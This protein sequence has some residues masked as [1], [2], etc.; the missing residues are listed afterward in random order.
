VHITDGIKFV[1]DAEEG[2]YDAIIVDSSDPVGPAEVL[3][4][5]VRRLGGGGGEGRAARAPLGFRGVLK[6]GGGAEARSKHP[7]RGAAAQRGAAVL[8][9][10]AG[11]AP[12]HSRRGL[13]ACPAQ[14]RPG[15]SWPPYGHTAARLPGTMQ[16]LPPRP[17]PFPP[18]TPR[19]PF[20]RAMHRA[21]RPGGVVCTQAESLWLHLDIIKALAAMCRRVFEGGSVQYAYTTIPT[22][23]S[24]QI[25]MMV[26]SKARAGG[27]AP[28]DARVPRQP[29]PGAN[30]A[31]G[32]PHLRWGRAL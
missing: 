31:L 30:A 22:Y 17:P 13:R 24:G 2:T 29:A 11:G 32:I 20:F 6:V 25:G 21:V 12:R 7:G 27:G 19:Q 15:P 18:A 16:P 3:F 1:E 8:G 23:P 14:P 5:E 28:L 10:G 9:P 4:E 26:C